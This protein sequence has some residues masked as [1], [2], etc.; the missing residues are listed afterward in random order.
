[1]RKRLSILS[2]V[3]I[4]FALLSSPLTHA[5]APN[6]TPAAE[7][8]TDDHTLTLE[9]T[10]TKAGEAGALSLSIAPKSPWKWNPEYPAKLE[11]VAPPGVTFDKG[12]LTKKDNDFA[13]SGKT[14]GAK[15][16]FKAASPGTHKAIVKGRFGLC[17]ANV[18]IIKKV[19]TTAT[20]VVN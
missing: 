6:H 18:C 1:M 7:A 4:A 2:I 13:E 3:P 12:L 14:V 19:E 16:G 5:G 17:D 10:P 11:L 8:P 9:A 20:I 15:A